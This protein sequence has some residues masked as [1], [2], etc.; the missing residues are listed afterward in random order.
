METVEQQLQK[1]SAA[2]DE[3]M[4]TNDASLIAAFMT[5]DWVIVGADG[6]TSK[7]NFL[8]SIRSGMLTHHRMDADEMTIK[9]YGDTAVVIS[10]GT[11]AGTFDKMEFSFYEWSASTFIQ[12]EGRWL[13][14]TT[15]LTPA[16]AV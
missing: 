4:L 8:Q 6:I 11:S 10:K 9:T 1:V 12:Q 14:I 7:A 3:A 5:D 2:W 13:C 16:K 15:M